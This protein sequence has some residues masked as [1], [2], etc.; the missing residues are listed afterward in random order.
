MIYVPT[1]LILFS[2]YVL[3]LPI[4]SLRVRLTTPAFRIQSQWRLPFCYLW[5]FAILKWQRLLTWYWFDIL[6]KGMQEKKG[7]NVKPTATYRS[8]ITT[9]ILCVI[10][11][12]K[13]MI[14]VYFHWHNIKAPMDLPGDHILEKG[15]QP[16]RLKLSILI[17]AFQKFP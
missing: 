17:T 11:S 6:T 13:I 7:Q 15:L 2:P 5:V 16:P 14:S 3:G 10:V 4:P 12:F 8:H 1:G 9:D